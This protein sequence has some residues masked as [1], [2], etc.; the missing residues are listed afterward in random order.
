MNVMSRLKQV[1]SVSTI[2]FSLGMAPMSQTVAAE[3]YIVSGVASWDTLNMRSQ[4][5]ASSTIIGEIPASGSNVTSNGESTQVGRSTWVKVAYNGVSGW[6]N[7][8]YL[9][10]DY[11]YSAI[12]AVKTAPRPAPTP[13]P[14]TVNR[15]GISIYAAGS[16]TSTNTGATRSVYVG[17]GAGLPPIVSKQRPAPVY[18]NRTQ[19]AAANTANTHSHP[20]NRCTRSVSHTHPNGANQHSHRYSCQ[21][22]AQPAARP[23]VQVRAANV[24]QG[25][26]AVRVTQAGSH[27]HPRNQFTN[28]VTHS[29]P[30]GTAGHSHN[31]G[32]QRAGNNAA[33]QQQQVR[34][35][36]TV[37]QGALVTHIHP[38]TQYNQQ[39][40]HTH[41]G[42][43]VIHPHDFLMPRAAVQTQAQQQVQVS[44]N[45]HTH[46]KNQFTN[47]VTHTHLNGANSH[48]HNYGGAR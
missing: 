3:R 7:K 32:G 11:S 8:R 37:A 22:Q 31:Y 24:N 18:V 28:A 2:I 44:A 30:G 9:A 17:P 36:V 21:G 35:Q 40:T 46:P 16:S 48:N 26:T 14:A 6:V 4:P 13:L 27:T 20:A 25:Q 34:Q 33:T 38:A 15:S 19:V 29:H 43:D 41:A 5:N 39:V 42:G 23:Q 1:A 10:T 45:T 12:P 47:S